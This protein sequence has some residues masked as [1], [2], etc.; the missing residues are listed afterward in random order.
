MSVQLRKKACAGNK[1]SYYLDIYH[2]NE[3]HYEFLKMYLF[4]FLIRSAVQ[5]TLYNYSSYYHMDN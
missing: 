5:Y 1:Q 3:R 4:L 2:N